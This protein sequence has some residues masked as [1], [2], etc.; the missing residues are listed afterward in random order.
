MALLNRVAILLFTT[1]LLVGCGSLPPAL[2]Q[3]LPEGNPKPMASDRIAWIE[4]QFKTCSGTA[5]PTP[6]RKTLAIVAPPVAES[7]PAPAVLG[8]QPSPSPVASDS[9]VATAAEPANATILFEYGQDTPSADGQRELERLAAI[10]AA[11]QR[12]ELYGRTDD[13][14]GKAYN[15]RLARR[16]A[17]SV[18]SWLLDR[19]VKAEIVVRAEGL[20]CYLDPAPTEAARRSNRRVEV[21]LA[22]RHDELSDN[23]RKGA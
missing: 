16:R 7:D 12:I 23:N 18:R 20:C 8:V 1:S 5:C 3:V 6:T 17:E 14:G 10:S 21:R 2:P 4:R 19:G 22:G 15:D 11:Y 9:P 13:I